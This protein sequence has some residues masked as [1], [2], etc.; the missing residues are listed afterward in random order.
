MHFV[1]CSLNRKAEKKK[2]EKESLG[3]RQ[4]GIKYAKK[5]IYISFNK[6]NV[7]MHTAYYIHVYVYNIVQNKKM[8][9]S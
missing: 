1:E 2:I 7:R 5:K 6:I 8:K 3:K 9:V 4:R